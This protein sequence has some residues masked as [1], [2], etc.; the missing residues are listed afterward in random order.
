M[1]KIIIGKVLK[2]H[3]LKGELKIKPLTDFVE[4]RFVKGNKV[5]IND[6]ELVIKSTRNFKGSILVIFEGYEDINLVEKFHSQDIYDFQDN[7]ILEED[8]FFFS[9]LLECEVYNNDKLVGKVVDILENPTQDVLIIKTI[10]GN[11][12]VPYVDAFIKEVDIEAKIIKINVIKG[13][14]DED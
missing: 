6:T 4:E 8:Q 9:D 10:N 13:L 14:I 5:F 12:M 1:E 11:K 2:T 7:I 3:G